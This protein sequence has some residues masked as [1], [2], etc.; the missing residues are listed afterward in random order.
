MIIFQFAVR[1]LRRHW[2]RS[3][4][5]VIG[6]IIGVFA[7]ASLGIMG[8]SLNILLANVITDVGDTLVI[9]PHLAVSTGIS[10]DPRIIVEATISPEQVTE[11][12]RVAGPNAVIPV[13]QDSA[14]VEYGAEYGNARII[15]LE[16][17]DI[18]FLLD[19]EEG[20]LLRQNSQA[21]LVGTFLAR[22]FDI[23]AGARIR[24]GEEYVRVAGVL[25]ERGFAA[26]INPDYGVIVSRKWYGEHI[27]DPDAFAMVI[28][29]MQDVAEID[30]VKDD[31][32]HQLNRYEDTVD[33][34]DSRDM[35]SEYQGYYDQITQF[36][37]GIGAVSL[38][39]AAVNILNVMYISVTERIHEIGVLRSIGTVRRDILLM[40]LYEAIV[41][42]LIGSIIGAIMSAIG[43]YAISVVTIQA[44]TVGTTFG[45]NITVFNLTS[46]AYIVFASL[47]GVGIS[48]LS[49]LYPA[50]KASKLTPIEALRHE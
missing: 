49:G 3:F 2:I 47:F 38:L 16:T 11:I 20:Q 5:S 31:I 35:L 34:F 14:E 18:P 39:I 44:F 12:E 21:C 42:G 29:K 6:I 7:I 22:E 41:L 45:E 25:E 4:L 9:S 15:G 17:E 43:G 30:A 1:N 36:L 48:A 24:I 50:W 13:L 32:D 23:R 26:D 46:V 40:F 37:V 10:G 28:I 19:V 8:N 33:I 27:G